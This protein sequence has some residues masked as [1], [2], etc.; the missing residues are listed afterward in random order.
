[1]IG[2]RGFLTGLGAL[3]AAPAIVRASSLMPVKALV[4]PKAYWGIVHPENFGDLIDFD[5]AL[6]QMAEM[7]GVPAGMLHPPRGAVGRLAGI[8]FVG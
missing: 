7:V 1:M 5:K 8:R 3:I 6:R 4:E 2:R